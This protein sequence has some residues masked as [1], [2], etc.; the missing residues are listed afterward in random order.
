MDHLVFA[1][2]YAHWDWDSPDTA[3]PAWLPEDMKRKIFYDNAAELYR[4]PA[5]RDKGEDGANPD[6]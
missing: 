5:R 3:L 6:V 4:L 2:D 1:S